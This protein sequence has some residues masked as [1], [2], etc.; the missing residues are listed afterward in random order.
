MAEKTVLPGENPVVDLAAKRIGLEF[1]Q[2]RSL[3]LERIEI[4]GGVVTDFRSEPHEATE[5][6][7]VSWNREIAEVIESET[8]EVGAR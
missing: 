8:L 5:A 4:V 6:E 7:L 1:E 2:A 3:E